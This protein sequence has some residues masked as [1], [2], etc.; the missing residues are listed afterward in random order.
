MLSESSI[1]DQ[2]ERKHSERPYC[3][4]GRHTTPVYRHGAIWLECSIVN[5]P[6]TGRVQRLWATVTAPAHVHTMI[7]EVPAPVQ[8]AA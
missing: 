5:E 1:V 7:V 4:C 8:Q 2:I 6:I 3:E